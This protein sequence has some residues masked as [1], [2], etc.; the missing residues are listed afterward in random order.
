MLKPFLTTF[1]VTL[2]SLYAGLTRWRPGP[3]HTMLPRCQPLLLVLSIVL[4][5]AVS[6]LAVVPAVYSSSRRPISLIAPHLERFGRDVGRHAPISPG[7][8]R[9]CALSMG[10]QEDALEAETA[11]VREMRASEIKKSLEEMSI[12]TKGVYEVGLSG[13]QLLVMTCDT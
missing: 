10:M 5:C 8:Q 4:P 9:G 13:P 7:L 1:F 3:L 6:W 11:A 2:S 12:A